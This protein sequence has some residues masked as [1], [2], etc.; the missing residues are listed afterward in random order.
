MLSIENFVLKKPLYSRWYKETMFCSYCRFIYKAFLNKEL[1]QGCLSRILTIGIEHLVCYD[2]SCT[3]LYLLVKSIK[4]RQLFMLS[5]ENFVLKKP[6]Y[7]RWYKETMF[8]SYCRFIYKAFLNKE[9]LQGCLSRILTIGIEHLVCYDES[10]TP[11]YLLVKSI[12]S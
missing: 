5:I 3:P 1:L 6:L 9:L 4:N 11:L 12:K 2:E 10:C 7:S 8:C